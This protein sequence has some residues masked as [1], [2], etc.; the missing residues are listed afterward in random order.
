MS[1]RSRSRR[2]LSPRP[3]NN[4]GELLPEPLAIL[5]SGSD[6]KNAGLSPPRIFQL[7]NL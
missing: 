2:P 6:L 4:H 5:T 7:L 1:G 3:L